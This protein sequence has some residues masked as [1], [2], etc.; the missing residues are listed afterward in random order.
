MALKIFHLTIFIYSCFIVIVKEG[1]HLSSLN[2]F[3]KVCR[4][5]WKWKVIDCDVWK[6]VTEATLLKQ[7]VTPRANVELS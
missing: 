4:I 3:R 2:I 5:N 6:A 7:D 1:K